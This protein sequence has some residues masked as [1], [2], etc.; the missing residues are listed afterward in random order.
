MQSH[1]SFNIFSVC[2]VIS[3]V[4]AAQ[5]V[6]DPPCP[7]VLSLFDSHSKVEESV[8]AFIRVSGSFAVSLGLTFMR[9]NCAHVPETQTISHFQCD[10]FLH[11]HF[12]TWVQE[13]MQEHVI[14]SLFSLVSTCMANSIKNDGYT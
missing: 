9:K 6:T 4:M 14:Q 13:Q 11:S 8:T 1:D 2:V 7:S 10:L 3:R 5:I 12:S